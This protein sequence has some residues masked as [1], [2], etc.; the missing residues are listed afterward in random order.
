MLDIGMNTYRCLGLRRAVVPLNYRYE[1]HHVFRSCVADGAR[2]EAVY[3][4]SR[5][6]DQDPETIVMFS[7]H[8]CVNSAT[9][10]IQVSVLI[11]AN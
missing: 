6:E 2:R 4:S 10:R 5:E 11:C 3:V 1:F 7:A 9:V 8:L